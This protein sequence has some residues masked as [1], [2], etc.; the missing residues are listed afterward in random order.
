MSEGTLY[1][2][3]AN[4]DLISHCRCET[5]P[6][7]WPAQMD[8]PWCGCGWLFVCSHCGQ[9]FTFARAEYIDE[10]IEKIAHRDLLRR[11]NDEPTT[12][13]IAEWV[14]VMRILQ[15]GIQP[16]KTYVY[17]DGYCLP[18]DAEGIAFEGWAAR[19]ELL[20]LPHIDAMNDPK[21]LDLTIG[22]RRYWRERA[23]P[24]QQ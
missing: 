8:C 7:G 20:H 10:P 14:Q 1:L 2:V 22:N 16:G 24:E 21:A 23:V 4:D 11:R 13:D 5:A 19:H 18:T 17:L 3:K 6:I 12:A 15:K 9:A